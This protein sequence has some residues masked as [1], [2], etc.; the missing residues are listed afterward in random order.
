MGAS[1]ALVSTGFERGG[2]SFTLGVETGGAGSALTGSGAFG[3][4]AEGICTETVGAGWAALARSCFSASNQK[5]W[6]EPEGRPAFSQ[7]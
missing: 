7:S 4:A 6:S 2:E 5:C 1:T 3:R